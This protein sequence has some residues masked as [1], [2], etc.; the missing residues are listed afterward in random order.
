MVNIMYQQIC[1]PFM[2]VHANRVYTMHDVHSFPFDLKS[3]K[4][5][6]PVSLLPSL[7]ICTACVYIGT[8]CITADEYCIPFINLSS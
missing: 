7:M 6:Q 8:S 5:N 1:M 3:N 4:S 2:I